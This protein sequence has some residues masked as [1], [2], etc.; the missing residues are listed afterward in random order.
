MDFDLIFNEI[1]LPAGNDT[2][3]GLM[4]GKVVNNYDQDHL[5][6]VQVEVAAYKE[7]LNAS[8]WIRVAAPMA[9][10][11]KGM[12]FLPEVGDEVLIGFINNNVNFPC[13]IGCLWS[14]KETY[15]AEA[16]TEKNIIKKITT[17]SG[18]EIIFNEEKGK[19]SLTIHTPK[20]LTI[21]LLDEDEKIAIQD[22][23]GDNILSIDSKGGTIILK[24]K[25][26]LVLESETIEIK[27]SKDC[28]I[29]ANKINAAAQNEVAI[30]GNSKVAAEGG[31]VDVN[32]KATLNLKSS[33]MANLKGSMVKIN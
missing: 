24:A 30:T 28:K 20:N 19:E 4:T 13:V 6:M 2:A 23:K 18:H 29:S 15:P 8:G 10:K 12:Y 16:V 14:N 11:E 21:K 22:E 17:L 9:G 31:Q 33:G 7:G 26:S 5:G 3:L 32:A 25:K 1:S 27:A